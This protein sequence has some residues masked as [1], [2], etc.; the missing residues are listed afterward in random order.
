[1]RYTICYAGNTAVP[2]CSQVIRDHLVLGFSPNRTPEDSLTLCL[3]Q[4]PVPAAGKE[5]CC[6]LK[7]GNETESSHKDNCGK[8]LFLLGKKSIAVS[9]NNTATT[10]LLWLCSS[11]TLS[12]HSLSDNSHIH[13]VHST[14]TDNKKEATLE[15]PPVPF[16]SFSFL[17]AVP[18]K[19]KFLP[20]HNLSR[21]LGEMQKPHL[22]SH[23]L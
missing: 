9:K 15:L 14:V 6:G 2:S 17:S 18:G 20:G 3:S 10:I 11:T 23:V 5:S 7:S 19:Y 1:M 21:F 8:D 22:I 16:F 13:S 12:V 4:P